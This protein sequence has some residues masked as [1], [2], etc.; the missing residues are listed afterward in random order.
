MVAIPTSGSNRPALSLTWQIRWKRNGKA[1][2]SV[3]FER[4]YRDGDKW[5]SA[6][7]FSG[8][9]LL[10]LEKVA[11]LAYQEI[12]KLRASDKAASEETPEG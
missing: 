11:F 2:Y 5:K 1:F 4:S 12:A 9:D 7:S 6:V 3:T 10:L 8:N